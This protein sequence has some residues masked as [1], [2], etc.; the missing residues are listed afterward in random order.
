MLLGNRALKN[1]IQPLFWLVTHFWAAGMAPGQRLGCA[2][3][4]LAAWHAAA[5]GRQREGH[6]WRGMPS[7]AGGGTLVTSLESGDKDLLSWGRGVENRIKGEYLCSWCSGW[8]ARIILVEDCL[9]NSEP[10]LRRG[11]K[12]S[13][14]RKIHV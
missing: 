14:C 13:F 8:K 6:R 12:S 9:L 1:Y 3:P 11:W 2:V 10:P 4:M 5:L 7:L